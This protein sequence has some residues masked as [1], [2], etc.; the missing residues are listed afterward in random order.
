MKKLFVSL[1]LVVTN[2]VYAL[3]AM[4]S[5]GTCAFLITQ[6]V[7]FGISSFPYRGTGYNFMGTLSFNNST[8]GVMNGV[9]V[10]VTYT[11]QDSPQYEHSAILKNVPFKITPMTDVNG[12]SGGY[13]IDGSGGTGYKT[14][15]PNVPLEVGIYANIIPVNEGKS[16]LM[17]LS[18]RTTASGPGPGRLD[19]TSTQFWARG[20]EEL[21]SH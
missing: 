5:S 16:I 20:Q 7:P 17:Q 13:I 11:N 3:P 21:K 2:A 12:F 10:N 15:S 6:P 14:I 1:L 8:S 4:P 9:F 19:A 18:A